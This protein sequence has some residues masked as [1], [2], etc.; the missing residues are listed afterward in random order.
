MKR[1]GWL[2]LP[3]VA[4]VAAVLAAGAK[5]L[6]VSPDAVFYVGTARNWL[7][8][9]GFA[10]PAGVPPLEHF[11]PGFTMVL[12][13]LGKLGL[14][15]LTGARAVNAL[16]LGGIVLLVGLVVRRSTGSVPAALV[17]SVLVA[18]GVDLLGLSGSA[19]SE[20]MFILLA[21]A[22]IV[23]LAAYLD[24]PRPALLAGASALVAAAF[25]T[26]YV[27]IAVVV[28]GVAVLA[29]RRRWVAA[30][31]FGAATVA[32]VALWLLW[33]GG[34]A[35]DRS[36]A[37][38]LFGADYLGQAV[39]PLARWIVPWP[40]PPAGFV[41]AVVLV[42]AGVVVARRLPA[43]PLTWLLVAFTVAYLVVLVANRTFTDATGR[44]DARFLA[45]L[46]VAAILLAVPALHRL[47]PPALYLAGAL[48]VA[49]VAGAVVWTAGGLTD[50]SIR[51]RGYSAAALQ[52]SSVMAFDGQPLYSNAPD[53]VSFIA[54]RPALAIPVEKDYLTGEANARFAEELAAMRGY[55]AYFDAITF[56]RSFQ[57]SRTDLE[58][59]LRLE[60]VLHDGV[61]TLYRIL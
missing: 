49:Q 19:L 13:A 17:A 46:H 31:V 2:A 5:G 50:D 56:K 16:A 12:A 34:G 60:V 61:G 40:G 52:H 30:G 10:P 9:L 14:D 7:D 27:G 37:F 32:P 6:Y 57:P 20:P 28:A 39:R 22:G 11:P 55:I 15:P 41:L 25:L 3:P 51:R 43:T 26:R 58:A 18:A 38:H 1:S 47:E 8:G 45:P 21:L 33:A 29:W 24:A 36:V 44:L 59:A 54:G 35:S 53:A 42:A 4:A 23:A 48:V